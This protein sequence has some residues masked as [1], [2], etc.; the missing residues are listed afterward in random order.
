MLF[1]DHSAL[2][3]HSGHEVAVSKWRALGRRV[4]RFRALLPRAPLRPRCQ[5][6]GPTSTSL[7]TSVKRLAHSITVL[8]VTSPASEYKDRSHTILPFRSPYFRAMFTSNFK[9]AQAGARVVMADL[10]PDLLYALLEFLYYES[11][12]PQAHQLAFE[13]LGQCELMEL[14]DLR[15]RCSEYDLVFDLVKS[16]S[17]VFAF[18]PFGSLLCL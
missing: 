3:H 12:D 17:L 9:E 5:V 6:R 8:R 11:L 4:G 1:L 7:S 16:Q 13:L 15:D 14:P 2:S 10:E 18:P